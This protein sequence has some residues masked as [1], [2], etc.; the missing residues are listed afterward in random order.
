MFSQMMEGFSF[1]FLIIAINWLGSVIL[2]VER[3]YSLLVRY[4]IMFS[5]HAYGFYV[6][7][8]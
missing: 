7:I 2:E 3:G 5:Q 6:L 1:S 4:C 8:F